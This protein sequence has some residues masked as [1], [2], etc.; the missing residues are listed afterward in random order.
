MQTF[1]M[2]LCVLVGGWEG[3]IRRRASAYS[4]AHPPTYLP[5]VLGDE[6]ARCVKH[7]VD[8]AVA[9]QQQEGV[10]L[11]TPPSSFSIL[12]EAVPARSKGGDNRGETDACCGWVGVWDG[13]RVGGW[14]DKTDRVRCRRRGSFGE[15]RG[16][17]RKRT[18]GVGEWVGG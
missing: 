14:M 9:H 15:G 17:D 3:G 11:P 8:R 16:G 13:G 18:V 6:E 7:Q 10:V 5:A 2:A 1:R 12:P 4:I